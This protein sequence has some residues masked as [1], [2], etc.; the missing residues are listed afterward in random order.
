[1]AN[2]GPE[3]CQ[4]PT[5]VVGLPRVS[6]MSSAARLSAACASRWTRRESPPLRLIEVERHTNLP[7]GAGR[8]SGPD[9]STS[10]GRNAEWSPPPWSLPPL[11]PRLDASAAPA[12]SAAR[13]TPWPNSASRP[14]HGASIARR[15]RAARSMTL[16]L[17]NAGNFSVYG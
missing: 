1:M 15:E 13:C 2:R 9:P 16:R 4:V 6:P 14:A 10:A 12:P 17:P 8:D 11:P 3:E 5:G 7:A